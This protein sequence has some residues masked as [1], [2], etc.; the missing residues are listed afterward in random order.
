MAKII[1]LPDGRE[2]EFPDD[3]TNDAIGAVLSKQFGSPPTKTPDSFLSRAATGFADPIVGAGQIADRY[4]VNPIRQAISPGA[5]SMEDVTRERDASYNAPEGFDAARMAGNVANPLSWGGGAGVARAAVAGAAQ[6]GLTPVAAD[7]NFAAEKAKQAGLGAAG[8]AVLTKALSG[9]R[10][11][12]EARELMDQGIQPTVG[13][14]LGGMANRVEQKLSSVPFVGDAIN[15]ARN[16]AQG[17]FE[18]RYLKRALGS[19]ARSRCR[20]SGAAGN[21]RRT[22]HAGSGQ[23]HRLAAVRCGCPAPAARPR[24]MGRA[25]TGSAGGNA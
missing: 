10:A 1:E 14:S 3:M 7:A 24:H 23:R 19:A 20:W 18:A 16:R 13:Q 8:G 21:R 15:Y 11:T 4:L 25:A 12:P 17:E 6:G 5:T 9:L 2:A 22:D